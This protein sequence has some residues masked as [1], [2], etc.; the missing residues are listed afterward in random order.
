W[1]YTNDHILYLQDKGGDE[2]WKVYSVHLASGEVKDLTPF[3]TIPGPDGNPITL[4]DGTVLRPTARIEGVSER[5]PQEIL[6]GLNNRSP[7][8]HDLYLVD[9]GTG[10]MELV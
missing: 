3:E 9:I 5:R 1:A 8:F 4:P 6:V 2:N 7:Q 10:E